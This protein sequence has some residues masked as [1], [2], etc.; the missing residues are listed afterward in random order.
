[1]IQIENRK[2]N[3]KQR[4]EQRLQRLWNSAYHLA[5]MNYNNSSTERKW[6]RKNI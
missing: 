2:K 6:N 3:V 1:M 5:Y 4:D